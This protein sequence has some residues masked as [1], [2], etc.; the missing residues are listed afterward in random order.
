MMNAKQ[1][2]SSAKYLYDISKGSLVATLAGV[3]TDK[4]SW[5][6]IVASLVV[7][8]YAFTAAYDLED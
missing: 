3:L 4:A 8:F 5:L 7:A 2:E 1:R 6:G